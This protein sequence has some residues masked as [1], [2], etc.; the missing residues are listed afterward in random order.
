MQWALVA[1]LALAGGATSLA[2]VLGWGHWK[3]LA[4]TAAVVVLVAALPFKVV[5]TRLEA[6]VGRRDERRR[7]LAESAVGGARRRVQDVEDLTRIGVHPAVMPD[8][9]AEVR[10]RNRLPPY[11]RR[12]QHDAVVRCLVPG[13]FVMVQGDS[14]AG[15]SRLTFEA[16]RQ[17]LAEHVLFAPEPSAL[18]AAIKEMRQIRSAVL[19]L[20]DLDRYVESD[21]LTVTV[22]GELLAG[23]GHQRVVVA[24][25]RHQAREAIFATEDTATGVVDRRRR[26]LEMAEAVL[27]SREFT[28]A[29]LNRARDL[30]DDPRIADALAHADRYGLAEYLAAGPQLRD[31]WLAGR[32]THPRG[33]ALVAAAVDCRCAGFIAPLPTALLDAVHVHYLP[34]N[35]RRRIEDR[36]TAWKWAKELWRHTSAMLEPIN[37]NIDTVIGRYSLALTA[38]QHALSQQTE[39]NHPDTLA[40]RSNLAMVLTELGR[41]EEAEREHRAVLEVSTQVLGSAHHL[42]LASRGNLAMVLGD[43]G[44]LEESERESRVVF[45]VMT[46]V[47][48]SDHPDTLASRSNY[49]L[50]LSALGRLDE[51]EQEHRAELQAC[52]RVLGPDHPSTLT[53]RHNHALV[54]SA[55]G[56]LEEAEREYR[57]VLEVMM[58]VLGPDHPNTLITRNDFARVLRALGK[59]DEDDT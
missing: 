23:E 57:A 19:W 14:G 37:T 28:P 39:P 8:G 11:V 17:V 18:G 52:A 50:V 49:A 55:L 24:T 22:V 1:V 56:R 6:E 42:A 29:E 33:A 48:G 38:H 58:R 10:G 20:D 26:L 5:S 47:L 41:L 46:R 3:W 2:N 13:G 27:I 9:V 34:S 30:S 35:P 7:V 43:L 51:A 16:I 59:L 45:E 53:S 25:L 32:D 15:K 54:L 12:D 36:D 21:V 44:K 4:V 40:S 31:K